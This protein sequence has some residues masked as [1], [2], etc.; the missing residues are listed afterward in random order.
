MAINTKPSS[1]QQSDCDMSDPE[2]HFLWGLAQIPVGAEMMP[3]QQN[4]ARNMSKHLHELG[5]RH[6]PKLQTKKLQM[7]VRGQQSYLNG[8]ARWVPMDTE[9]PSPLMLPDVKAMTAEERE[10]VHQELKAV[11][12]IEPPAEDIGPTAQVISLQDIL[13]VRVQRETSSDHLKG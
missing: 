7:P 9:D 4:T 8:L 2:E 6:H 10:W 3:V 13:A 12:H 11:G 5:Y 1:P